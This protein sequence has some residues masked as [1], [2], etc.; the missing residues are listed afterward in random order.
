MVL[1]FAITALGGA[2][3]YLHHRV[4]VVFVSLATAMLALF[5][6]AAYGASETIPLDVAID[7]QG[8]TLGGGRTSWREIVSMRT[9]VTRTRAYVI[10]HTT[11][12]VVRLGPASVETAHAIAAAIRAVHPIA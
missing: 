7:A 11:E 2:Y 12:S 6:L 10:L 1:A 3:E 9:E 4:G 5:G 8:V